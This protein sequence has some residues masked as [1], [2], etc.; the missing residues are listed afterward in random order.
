MPISMAQLMAGSLTN[1]VTGLRLPLRPEYIPVLRATVGVLAG[2]LNFDYDEIMQLRVAVSEVF[3]LAVKQFARQGLSSELGVLDVRFVNRPDGL[4][5]LLAAP[6]DYLGEP[7]TGEGEE[8]QALLESLMH[9]VEF[10]PE[11]GLVRMVKYRSTP[12]T[13]TRR[14]QG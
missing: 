7:K 3:E 13:E 10:G 14:H 1:D 11:A 8:S 2:T 6:T 4:E 5:I 9:E 12:G